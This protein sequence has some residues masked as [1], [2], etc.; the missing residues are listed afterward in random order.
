MRIRT[1][2]AVLAVAGALAAAAVASLGAGDAKKAATPRARQALRM[3]GYPLDR[4]LTG[5]VTFPDVDLV[6]L[7]DGVSLGSSRWTTPDGSEPAYVTDGRA[8][9]MEESGHGYHVVTDFRASVERTLLGRAADEVAG[10]VTG[11]SVDGVDFVASDEI[12]PP[13]SAMT[14]RL[15]LAGE[16]TEGVLHPSFVYRVDEAGNAESL[17]ASASTAPASFTIPALEA[18]LAARVR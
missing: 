7:V 8:P 14:G 15:L 13:L 10:R 17:L 18:A 6:V 4:T 5:L 12:A 16:V 1:T 11:G 3:D 2:G 9:T